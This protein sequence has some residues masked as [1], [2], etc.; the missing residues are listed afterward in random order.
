ME[1]ASCVSLYVWFHS[2]DS[3]YTTIIWWVFIVGH[4]AEAYPVYFAAVATTNWDYF[5]ILFTSCQYFATIQY[6]KLAALSASSFLPNSTSMSESR[7]QSVLFSS[8]S[9]CNSLLEAMAKNFKNSNFGGLWMPSLVSQFNQSESSLATHVL[10]GVH[11]LELPLV[12]RDGDVGLY[13]HH[14]GGWGGGT[15][16]FRLWGGG[17][18]RMI[19]TQT[20]E[21]QIS[22]L[23]QQISWPLQVVLLFFSGSGDLDHF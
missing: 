17:K 8:S 12:L 23:N 19:L 13:F 21:G 2:S 1:L 4:A 18:S 16:G 14:W 20:R 15:R 9:F 3:W 5:L 10:C 6:L 22:S 7:W 11:Y